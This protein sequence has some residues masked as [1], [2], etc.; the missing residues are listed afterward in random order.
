MK[1]LTVAPFFKEGEGLFENLP[2]DEK[3]E[4]LSTWLDTKQAAK[5]LSITDTA[6]RLMAHRNQIP[7]YYLGSRLRFKLRD[8]QVLLHKKE[9]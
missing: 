3:K 2:V 6:L 8:C 1:S 4:I 7:A 5:I 9:K